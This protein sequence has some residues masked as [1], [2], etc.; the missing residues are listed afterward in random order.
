M[1]CLS[2]VQALPMLRCCLPDTCQLQHRRGE[3]VWEPIEAHAEDQ[4]EAEILQ[5]MKALALEPPPPPHTSAAS[6]APSS[7]ASTPNGTPSKEK[8]SKKE[9][10]AAQKLLEESHRKK[11]QEAAAATMHA[12]DGSPSAAAADQFVS[13]IA[14]APAAPAAAASS[15]DASSSASP[16]KLYWHEH[17]AELAAALDR[18]CAATT[19]AGASSDALCSG[20]E[21]GAEVSSK[22]RV[23]IHAAAA[24][25]GLDHE[26]L[27]FRPRRHLYVHAPFSALPASRL[28]LCFRMGHLYLEGASIDAIGARQNLK[29]DSD[30]AFRMHRA[31]RDGAHFHATIMHS[32]SVDAIREKWPECLRRAR[33]EFDAENAADAGASAAASSAAV[34]ASATSAAAVCP[35]SAASAAAASTDVIPTRVAE[36]LLLRFFVARLSQPSCSGPIELG[37]GRAASKDGSCVAYYRVLQWPEANRV[38]VELG[39]EP[40]DFHITVGFKT[41]D[42]H[43]VRKDVT[44]LCEPAEEASL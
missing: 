1:H 38:R 24:Q 25:R 36:E 19:A 4:S 5:Q 11:K 29:V 17:Q 6:S 13:P 20:L 18:V 15:D 22:D 9:R 32:S 34:A 28:L 42:I 41:Q 3:R 26:S 16:S 2:G 10:K 35:S 8:L 43:G 14:A 30:P 27:G 31:A 7:A 12:T 39:L 21:F 23:L 40:T 33:E 44:T 37:L